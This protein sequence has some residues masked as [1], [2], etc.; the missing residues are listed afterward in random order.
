MEGGSLG[1]RKRDE[2]TQREANGDAQDFRRM[3]KTA[4]EPQDI[5]LE[6]L[7]GQVRQAKGGGE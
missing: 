5:L 3:D 6:R 1:D 2:R 7:P 4:A